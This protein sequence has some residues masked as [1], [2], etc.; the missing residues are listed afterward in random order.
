[1]IT[2]EK[3]NVFRNKE[4]KEDWEF[5]YRLGQLLNKMQKQ[6]LIA[7]VND[8]Q[9]KKYREV[10]EYCKKL[11]RENGGRIIPK[12]LKPADI[13]GHVCFKADVLD[14]DGGDISEFIDTLKKTDSISIYA[15]L[16]GAV[17]FETVILD[18]FKNSRVIE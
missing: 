5:A 13:S 15:T 9:Y 10:Y 3:G 14:I 12:K 8:E 1:M 4:E 7:E 6:K 11:A 18:V 16:D 17:H 2:D